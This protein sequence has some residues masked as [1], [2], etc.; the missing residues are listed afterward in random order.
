MS[1][2]FRLDGEVVL[3]T[4]AVGGLGRPM[5]R[6]LATA[7]AT[8]VIGHLGDEGRAEELSAELT[9]TGAGA[10]VVEADVTDAE[11][12]DEMF[13]QIERRAGRCTVVVN[14]AGLMEEA[15]FLEMT[16]DQWDHTIRGD[17]TGPMLVCQRFARRAAGQGVIINVSSQLAFKGARNF[18][19]YSAAK[20]GVAG[21]TRALARELGPGIR[22]NAIAPGPVLTPLIEDLA[23]D[24]AWV[25][26]RTSG[27]VTGAIATPE[28]IAPVVVFLAA[29]ASVQLHGQVLHVNGGGVMM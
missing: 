12:V 18:V 15:P 25:A 21:L 6:A 10:L 24:P 14:N 20:A 16:Q 9:A 19:S 4:G 11:A 29:R 1:D 8:V 5:A 26:E 27:A 23:A 28:E 7:G 2:P 13:R 17:L 3:L 22:V